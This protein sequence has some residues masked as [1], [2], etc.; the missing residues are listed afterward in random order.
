M[1]QLIAELRYKWD[2]WYNWEY[3]ATMEF[4]QRTVPPHQI[5]YIGEDNGTD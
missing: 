2:R 3:Y 4:V 1:R 5:Y